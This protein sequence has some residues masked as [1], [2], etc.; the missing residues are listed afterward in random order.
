MPGLLNNAE[1]PMPHDVRIA[2]YADPTHAAAIR[3]LMDAYAT[4]IVGGG[5]ALPDDVLAGLVDALAARPTAFSVLAFV[6]GAPA[7]LA[8]CFEGF[9]TF[10]CRPLVNIHDLVVERSFR[11]RGLSQQMLRAIEGEARRRGACKLTLEVLSGNAVAQSAYRRFGFAGYALDP[12][13]GE[14]VFWQKGL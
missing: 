3:G 8:N 1:H 7:G 14:A 11:G 12:A 6:D 2:D 4:D 9:S 13:M 5:A 10:T